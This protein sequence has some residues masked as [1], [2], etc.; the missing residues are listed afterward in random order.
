[1]AAL[2]VEEEIETDGE[3]IITQFN[4]DHVITDPGLHTILDP[5]LVDFICLYFL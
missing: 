5:K 4:P 3:G 1:M 2:Q